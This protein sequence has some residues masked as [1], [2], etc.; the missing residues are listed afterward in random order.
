MLPSGRGRPHRSPKRPSGET[1]VTTDDRPAA[2]R[3]SAWPSPRHWSVRVK[4]SV[5]LVVPLVLVQQ[6][7]EQAITRLPPL[8][9]VVTR[10]NAP[11]DAVLARYSELIEQLVQLDTTLLRNMNASE[12]TGLANALAGLSAARNEATMQQAQM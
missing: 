6:Q 2:R 4:F 3:R 12:V 10:S 7:A 9:D 11:P 5:V 1:D 8:R